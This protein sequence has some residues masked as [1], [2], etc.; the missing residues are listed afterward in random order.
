M[1]SKVATYFDMLN[2]RDCKPDMFVVPKIWRNMTN[3]EIVD[4][5]SDAL[6]GRS[7]LSSELLE[8]ILDAVWDILSDNRREDK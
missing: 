5:V 6:P 4:L 2:N 1:R 8:K 3:Q 7:I